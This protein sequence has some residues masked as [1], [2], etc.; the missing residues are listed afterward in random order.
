MAVG[1]KIAAG[2]LKPFTVSPFWTFSVPVS[3]NESPFLVRIRVWER[4]TVTDNRPFAAQVRSPQASVGGLPPPPQPKPKPVVTITDRDFDIA[5]GQEKEIWLVYDLAQH[6]FRSWQI[7]GTGS[8]PPPAIDRP[9][10]E[11]GM[12]KGDNPSYLWFT[13]Q[14]RGI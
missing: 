14:D 1:A 13:A 9:A 7:P 8:V 12:I 2:P 6:R 10:G 5:P 4:E 11:K 3:S